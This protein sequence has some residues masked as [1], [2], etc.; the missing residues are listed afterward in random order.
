VE[1]LFGTLEL[2]AVDDEQ[3]TFE[4][5]ANTAAEDAH[6]TIVEPSGA[7][8]T[9]PIPLL[10]FHDQKTPVGEITEARLVNGQWLVK[11]TI[12]KVKEAGK[13]KD[14][15][16]QAWHQVKYEL[17]RGLSVGF[18]VLK[19]KGKKIL[20]W[21]WRELSLVTLPSNQDANI[22]AVRSAY[23]AASGEPNSNPGVSGPSNSKP[24][25][26]K[27]TTQERITALEARHGVALAR[28]DE[29]NDKVAEEGRTKDATEQEEYEGLERD[30]G[31]LIREITDLTKRNSL[32]LEKATPV[33][34]KES[35]QGSESR[36]AVTLVRSSGNGEKGI[37]FARQAMALAVCNGNRYEAADYVKRTFPAGEITDAVAT[38][39]QTRAAVAPGNTTNATFAAPLVVT[40]YLNDFLELLRPKTLIGNI[41]NL[42]HVPFNVS[43]PAQTAGG[44][45]K[46]VGQGKWKPVT[47]AQYAAVTLAFAK[48][49]GIIVLT[50]EL[51][52]LSTPSAEAA[53]RDELVKGATAFLDAQFVDA[54]VAAVA[55][56]NPASITNGV[57]GTA[58]SAATP[59]AAR[60]DIAARVAAMAALGY[61][62]NELVLIMSE[63]MAFNLGLMI[64]AVGQ[65]AFP[66]ISVNGGTLL[67]MPVVVS[68]AVGNQIIVAHTPSILIADEGGIEIDI[69][70]EAS[71]Q[72]DSAPTDPADATTV[73]VNMWQTNQ[74]ALRVERYITWGKARSTAVDRITAAA[75]VP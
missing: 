60:P 3:R 42:R 55:N 58:A 17:V 5:I 28:M 64:N 7:R 12:R 45:Y 15:T 21:A 41:P 27:M 66:G 26:G 59:A 36:G 73:L 24:R 50:E 31:A 33:V 46:W 35:K 10:W 52:R 49:A 1:R 34:A 53:V 8:F 71:L 2:R 14:A 38:G 9:L 67:G 32:N 43:M 18:N 20:E 47:N 48:A 4:G 6:G 63:S 70:R 56:V 62:V 57:A 69:S 39:L 40:N 65:P 75:Y 61:P 37:A 22:I 29:I 16:D 11:G 13:V 74:V 51:V 30:A 68:Q 54:T 72:L 44:T 25:H 23:L 19:E